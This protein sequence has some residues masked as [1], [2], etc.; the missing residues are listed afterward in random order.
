MSVAVVGD[1][2]MHGKVMGKV[3][4]MPCRKSKSC[5]INCTFFTKVEKHVWKEEKH[6][7]KGIDNK[8]Q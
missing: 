8:E 1:W 5:Q 4:G 2:D 6:R 3:E 7:E